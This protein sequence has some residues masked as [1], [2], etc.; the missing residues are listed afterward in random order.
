MSNKRTIAILLL[1]LLAFILFLIDT[2]I[3]TYCMFNPAYELDHICHDPD[4]RCDVE[5]SV[6]DLN[7][8]G[9]IEGCNCVCS[10]NSTVSVCSGLRVEAE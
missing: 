9:D 3:D 6:Y 2:G 7:F 8:T 5:C 4:L 1:L 10:D